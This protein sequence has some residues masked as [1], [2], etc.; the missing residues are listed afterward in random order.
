VRRRIN[1]ETATETRSAV[2]LDAVSGLRVGELLGL[3]WEDARFDRLELN[4]TRSVLRN[5][6]CQLTFLILYRSDERSG[7]WKHRCTFVQV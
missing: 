6:K 1:I 2:I 5:L 4:V 7:S 3:K